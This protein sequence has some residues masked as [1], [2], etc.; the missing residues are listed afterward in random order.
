MWTAP[1]LE[2]PINDKRK[3]I[4]IKYVN[5]AES[6]FFRRI[7]LDSDIQARWIIVEC[8]N[9]SKIPKNPEVDQLAMRF[10]P[11]RGRFGVLCYRESDARANVVLRCRDVA[12]SG[13]GY[14]VALSDS[15][16]LAMLDRIGQ[17]RRGSIDDYFAA[18]FSELLE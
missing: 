5:S 7:Y 14:I 12:K 10:S 2:T 4:D 8:K 1:K 9:Y 16:I 6:G 13:H 18:R 17:N 11:Q 3:R 15:E